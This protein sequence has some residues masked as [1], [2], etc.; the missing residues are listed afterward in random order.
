MRR[1][2]LGIEK[3]YLCGI[4]PAPIDRFGKVREKLG[5]ISLGAEH[6]V[7]WEKTASAI[8]TL[9]SL[10]TQGYLLLALEQ[11]RRSIPYFHFRA[12][13][14]AKLALVAGNEVRGLAKPVLKICGEILEIPMKG[15]KESLNVA[16]A[17]AIVGFHLRY[18]TEYRPKNQRTKEPKNY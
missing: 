12:K 18:S 9:K 10:K 5:K 4:T 16:V 1:G 13:L 8:R 7:K 6:S 15:E 3:L 2:V 11:S 14:G 17:R